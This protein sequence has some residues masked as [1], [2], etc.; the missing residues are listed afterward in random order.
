[1]GVVIGWA[2]LMESRETDISDTMHAERRRL[3]RAATA[4][5][6]LFSRRTESAAI[7]VGTVVDISPDG[8]QIETAE[9]IA[10]GDEI[11]IEVFQREAAGGGE[12]ILVRGAVVRCAQHAQGQWASGIRLHVAADTA[13]AIGALRDAGEARALALRIIG[14]LQEAGEKS[15]SPLAFVEACY[16]PEGV[17]TTQPPTHAP[18]RLLSWR[19]G[20]AMAALLAVMFSVL[21]VVRIAKQSNDVRASTNGGLANAAIST[22]EASTTPF[23]DAAQ[24]RVETGGYKV[25]LASTTRPYVSSTGNTLLLGKAAPA[26]KG[27]S[28]ALLDGKGMPSPGEILGEAQN[29]DE[30][31]QPIL[32]RAAFRSVTQRDDASP[33]E[34]FLGQL[35]QAQA[36]LTLRQPDRAAALLSDALRNPEGVPPVWVA[37]AESF[38][39]RALA[40]TAWGAPISLMEQALDLSVEDVAGSSPMPP[41][42]AEVADPGLR[43]EISTQDYTLTVYADGTEQVTYPVGLGRDVT[44]PTGSFRVANM[45]MNPDW[46]NRGD[47]VPAGAPNN[48]LGNRWMGLGDANGATP[49]GIHPTAEPE[50]IGG[51]ESQ[52]CVRMRPAD[53]VALFDLIRIG[54]PVYIAQ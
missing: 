10:V 5:K 42:S 6:A 37:A 28:V 29:F 16:A 48:P 49:Y 2:L 15:S 27:S 54:T 34:R 13:E 39:E 46:Y 40:A 22:A 12:V 30:T 1:M 32:A 53:A 8:M 9:P 23:G 17:N 38:Q 4:R 18:K 45:I 51:N 24:D 31:G 14:H 36:M 25:S 44:T 26:R 19:K 3:S 35:G 33:V 21:G 11:D 52:G 7:R 20:L 47:V 43:V 50:S 41:P